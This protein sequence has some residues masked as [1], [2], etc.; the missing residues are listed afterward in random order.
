MSTF[1]GGKFEGIGARVKVVKSC[2]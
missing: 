2:S 1:E